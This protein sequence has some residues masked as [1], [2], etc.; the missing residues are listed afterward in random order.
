MM[1][2][3]LSLI[4]VLGLIANTL[5]AWAT[6]TPGYMDAYYYFGGALQLARG[7]G[8]T[9]PYL[10]NY[11]SPSPISGFLMARERGWGGGF[12]APSH[13]YWMPLT[14]IVAA[15]FIALADASQ[16]PPSL[17]RA[18][19]IP[20]VLLASLLP[21]LSYAVAWHITGQRRQAL[22]AAL[23][24]LFSSFY[25]PFW[26][27]T[28]SFAL[29][30]LGAGSALWLIGRKAE[31]G[32]PRLGPLF[33]AGVCAGLAHLTR[34]DGVLILITLVVFLIAQSKKNFHLLLATCLLLLGY[35]LTTAPWFLRNLTLIGAP[36]ASGG[37]LTLWLTTYDDI[38][39]LH[40]ETL[41]P[42]NYLAAGWGAIWEGKWFGLTTA[43]GTAIGPLGSIAAFPF[44][45]I[46]LWKLRRHPRYAPA[47]IYGALLF[48]AMTFA[49]TF[50]GAR[51]GLFHSGA[52]LLPFVLPAALL[53]VDA[54]VEAVAR[55][56]PHWQPEK[57]KP[58]FTLLLV[59]LI[60]TLTA[61]LFQRRLATPQPELIYA[62]IGHW[63][64]NSNSN[65]IVMVG[66]PPG[67][68]YF[69]EQPAI[70]IPNGN[71]GD[72]LTAMRTYN[73][74]WLVLDENHP[75]AL[76][77]LYTAPASDARFQLRATFGPAANPVY[78]FEVAPP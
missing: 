7:H 45:L 39:T 4:F 20:F 3:D 73:A 51:G 16:S 1:R 67:F 33:L 23:L 61:V 24:T 37:T 68:Y 28:D 36:L 21:L 34:A 11:L 77:D 44:A 14:S 58:I 66:D 57:S 35:L 40:P 12:S 2:R 18:A 9:E 65:S 72:V 52:A 56:L 22:I 76:A 26:P 64:T 43:I 30:G 47:F 55:R 25:F 41:T 59:A 54:S 60:L 13:L 70:I 49:F 78:L 75:R 74:R 71:A 38:F 19:Q 27:T 29:Y 32:H 50:P 31:D 15:P 10:W 17:F 62:D 5:A 6:P 63:L 53:G 48:G 42:A 69:T 46:G 8:F